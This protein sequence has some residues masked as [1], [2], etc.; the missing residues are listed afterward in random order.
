MIAFT[1]SWYRTTCALARQ[2]SLEFHI[3]INSADNGVWLPN[4]DGVGEGAYHRELHTGKY[5]DEVERRLKTA[6]DREEVLGVLHKIRKEL[7]ENKFPY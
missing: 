6:T 3:P 2:I 5:Y 1:F 7:S 4:M